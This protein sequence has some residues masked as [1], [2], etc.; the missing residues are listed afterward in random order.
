MG[1]TLGNVGTLLIG[2]GEIAAEVRLISA[3]GAADHRF[4]HSIDA[5]ERAA[6][7][8]GLATAR[9]VLGAAA[10]ACAWAEGNQLTPDQALTATL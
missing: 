6:G 1:W 8:A 5:D 3:A 9:A 7:E 2:Q 10:F 4:P